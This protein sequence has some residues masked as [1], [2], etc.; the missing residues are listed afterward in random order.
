M[1]RRRLAGITP[2]SPSIRGK[3]PA[4]TPLVLPTA[5]HSTRGRRQLAKTT[6]GVV[7]GSR[8]A[9]GDDAEGRLGAPPNS[10]YAAAA[11]RRVGRRGRGYAR[12]AFRGSRRRCELRARARPCGR[13]PPNGPVEGPRGCNDIQQDGPQL[14]LH[15]VDSLGINPA[16]GRSLDA[17]IYCLGFS[18]PKLPRILDSSGQAIRVDAQLGGRLLNGA[19]EWIPGLYGV[20]LGFADAEHTSGAPYAEA[21]FM[22][23]ALRARDIAE[24]VGRQR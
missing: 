7:G 21:G 8:R 20:G 4:V 17:V 13:T 10:S 2:E 11:C 9:G 22:P 24:S 1:P 16:V 3:R 6:P 12:W 23:F 15:H 5:V 19:G 14:E 18:G